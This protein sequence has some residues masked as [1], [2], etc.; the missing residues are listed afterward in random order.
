MIITV[1]YLMSTWFLDS[2]LSTCSFWIKL[3]LHYLRLLGRHLCCAVLLRPCMAIHF[4]HGKCHI[5]RVTKKGKSCKTCLTNHVQSIS[6]HI[7]P[8]VINTLRSRHTCT[9]TYT[10]VQTK[11]ILKKPDMYWLVAGM[12]GLKFKMWNHIHQKPGFISYDIF[13][14]NN[15]QIW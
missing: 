3:V 12:S 4:I 2:E 14:Y 9:D 7:M 15:D 5:R 13:H 10:D 6:P 8:L 1:V 11:A